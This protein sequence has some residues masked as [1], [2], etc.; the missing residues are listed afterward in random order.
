MKGTKSSST[1]DSSPTP[2]CCT[3]MVR[4]ILSYGVQC[5]V[6]TQRAGFVLRNNPYDTLT[7]KM[8]LT[9]E[10]QERMTRKSLFSKFGLR[11]SQELLVSNSPR[12]YGADDT[13]T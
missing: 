4:A 7:L 1:T 8:R 2:P 12:G 6:L 11:E 9:G 5:A 10:K 3:N 13:D